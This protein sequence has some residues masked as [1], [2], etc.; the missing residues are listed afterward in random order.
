[1]GRENCSRIHKIAEGGFNK[2]FLIGTDDDCEVIPRIPTPISGSP[3][4]STASEVAIINFLRN[5]LQ[6]PVPKILDYSPS[7]V[8]RV[9]AEY[10]IMERVHGESLASRWLS[11]ST[12]EVKHIMTQIAEIEH[13]ISAFQFPGY[14]CLYHKRDI[15]EECHIPL[16]VGD[17]CIGPVASRQFWHDERGKMDLDRG[18]CEIFS[19]ITFLP[20]F[21]LD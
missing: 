7:A 11:L 20:F 14:G 12:E 2:V 8:N 13:K 1:M 21:E 16:Q 19:W 9:G 3:R 18:P 17:F 6:I 10:I 15:E 4:Y 5:V